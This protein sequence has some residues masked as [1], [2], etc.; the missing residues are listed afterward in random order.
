MRLMLSYSA[1][2]RKTSLQ[3]AAALPHTTVACFCCHF[4]DVYM[5]SGTCCLC[6]QCL[7]LLAKWQINALFSAVQAPGLGQ[8]VRGFGRHGAALCRRRGHQRARTPPPAHAHARRRA[9]QLP[10]APARCAGAASERWSAWLA[11]LI[12]E[13]AWSVHGAEMTSGAMVCSA[14]CCGAWRCSAVHGAVG[15]HTCLCLV[16]LSAPV[17]ARASLQGPGQ[18][19]LSALA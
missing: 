3:R 10:G 14:V 6:P 18:N 12:S 7:A 11:A 9:R 1:C 19:P 4:V 2:D 15:P 16:L 8:S 5:C 17:T 13:H